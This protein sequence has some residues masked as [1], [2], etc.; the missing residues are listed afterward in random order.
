MRGD[1]DLGRRGAAGR[2][3]VPLAD[4][5]PGELRADDGIV[6]QFAEDVDPGSGQG[7]SITGVGD[8]R[9]ACADDVQ[10]G[11]D[12]SARG[13]DEFERLVDACLA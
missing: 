3:E 1:H 7:G 12:V 8:A 2:V 13:P 6:D 10:P 9:Q 11:V 4:A 5:L